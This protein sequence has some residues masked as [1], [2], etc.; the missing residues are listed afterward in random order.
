MATPLVTTVAEGN[1]ID[2]TPS[3]A[4]AGGGLVLQ[5]D[6]FGIAVNAIAANALGA[7]TIE[8]I[9]RFP[10]VASSSEVIAVGDNHFLARG[11]G[12]IVDKGFRSAG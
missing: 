5:N 8:G 9:F 4:V 2:Y 11:S 6:L 10:K 1:S 3:S 12:G 7:L